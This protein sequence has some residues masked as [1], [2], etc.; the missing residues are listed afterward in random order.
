VTGPVRVTHPFH[1]RF[2][3]E[4]EVAFRRRNWGD[5]RVFYRDGQGHLASLPAGWTSVVPEDPVVVMAGGRAHFRITDLLEL[6]A[7]VARLRA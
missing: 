5:D 1:P 3:Q 7:L 2:G 4:L 6:A